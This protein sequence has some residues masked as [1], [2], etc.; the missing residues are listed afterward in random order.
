VDSLFLDSIDEAEASWLERNF[1]ELEVLEVV[2]AMSGD[3][4]PGPGCNSMAF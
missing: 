2:K 1:E 3:K 4:A